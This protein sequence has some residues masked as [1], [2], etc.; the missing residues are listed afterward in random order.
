MEGD[1]TELLR[2]AEKIGRATRID[3][4]RERYIEFAKR[5]LPKNIRFD[6]IR[7]V[8]DC[9]NGAGLQ[10]GARG[11]VGAGRRGHQ[12]RR[13]AQRPQHQQGLRLDRARGR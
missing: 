12:D 4:A 13:R 1:T 8:I 11:A 10:G 3:S 5:T 9:A 2:R 6:G 7:V